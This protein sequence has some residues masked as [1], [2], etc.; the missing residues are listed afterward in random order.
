LQNYGNQVNAYNARMGLY[1]NIAGAAGAY[2]G[3]R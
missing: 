3:T 2:A 1:G